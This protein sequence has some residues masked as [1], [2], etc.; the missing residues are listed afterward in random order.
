MAE[1]PEPATTLAASGGSV[2]AVDITRISMSPAAHSAEVQAALAMA[3]AAAET[4]RLRA[5]IAD[6]EHAAVIYERD[7]EVA[8]RDKVI[9]A[10][11]AENLQ[12]RRMCLR[13]PLRQLPRG[14]GAWHSWYQWASVINYG[15]RGTLKPE[16]QNPP[17]LAPRARSDN[18]Q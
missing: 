13:M 3:A 6:L 10:Q 9:A 5:I 12:L 16:D 1:T 17:P 14:L 11:A 8:E 7:K 4:V 18:A 2:S 15:A